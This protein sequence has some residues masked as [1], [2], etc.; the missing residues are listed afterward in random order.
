[1]AEGI[2]DGYRCAFLDV[3]GEGPA[4][5]WPGGDAR[6]STDFAPPTSLHRLL[7]AGLL[8]EGSSYVRIFLDHESGVG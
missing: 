8:G 4:F 7:L 6:R 5:V 3:S 1:M 2:D